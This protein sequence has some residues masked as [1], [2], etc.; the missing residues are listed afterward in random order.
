MSI[1]VMKQALG[2]LL[3]AETT[4]DDALSPQ[5]KRWRAKI[6]SAIDALLS[7]I[8]EQEKQE[9]VAWINTHDLYRVLNK[10]PTVDDGYVAPGQ[11]LVN[12][13]LSAEKHSY[14]GQTPLY[15]NPAPSAPQEKQEGK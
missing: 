1:E 8:A 13:T 14:Y 3:E 15:T 12:I 7:A 9:P 6:V 4:V 11:R 10:E 5:H 2:V